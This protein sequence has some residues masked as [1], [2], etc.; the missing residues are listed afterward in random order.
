LRS[1]VS[2]RIDFSEKVC[3]SRKRGWRVVDFSSQLK[4]VKYPMPEEMPEKTRQLF[5]IFRDAVHREQ[6]AQ[7]IY[8]RAAELC[9]DQELKRVLLG[10]YND[11][12]R[13]EA[14]LVK[15]YNRLRERYNVQA[16]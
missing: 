3:F 12:V 16:E 2:P 9:E 7:T 10:F 8:K 13:H 6:E 4:E 15:Q 14:A 5:L 1:A 11:E